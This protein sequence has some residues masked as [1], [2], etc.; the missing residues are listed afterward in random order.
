MVSDLPLLL[1]LRVPLSCAVIVRLAVLA[2][3]VLFRLRT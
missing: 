3:A 2:V 1:K